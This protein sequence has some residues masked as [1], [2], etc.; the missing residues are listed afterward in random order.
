MDILA[1]RVGAHPG[2]ARPGLATADRRRARCAKILGHYFAIIGYAEGPELVRVLACAM[3]DL[4]LGAAPRAAVVHARNRLDAWLR[5]LTEGPLGLCAVT[6]ETARAALITLTV[7]RDWPTDL[8]AES[9]SADF[10]AA[11][12]DAL[13]L[14]LPPESPLPM[15]EQSLD[16]ARGV[17][18]NP[19]PMPRVPG[20]RTRRA[21]VFGLT[22]V[23]TTAAT[24]QMSRVFQPGGISEI[25]ILLMVL[26]AINFLWIALTFCSGLLGLFTLSRSGLPAGLVAPQVN[27]RAPRTAILI[28]IYNEDPVRIF[29]GVTA[30]YGSLHATGELAAFDFY[31]LS[32]STKPDAW[33]AEEILWDATRRRLGATGRLFYRRRFDNTARKAGNLAEFCQRWGGHYEAMLV[34]DADSLMEGRTIV[35]MARIMAANPSVGLLQTVPLLINRNTL[36][37]RAQQFASRVY[38]PVLATGLAAWHGGDGNYWGH[39]AMLRVRAFAAH[40]GMPALAGRPPFGGHILSHDFVEAA[41]L[42]RAG[43]G[44][45]MLPALGGSFEESPPTLLDHAQRDRRWCQGN[46]QHMA[47]IGAA[48]LH[49]M[50]RFHLLTGIMS[51]LASP[52]WFGFIVTGILAALQTRVELPQYF[53]PNRTPYPVWHVIDP[54]LAV[55]LL[56]TTMAVLL[57]PKVFGWLALAVQPALAASFGGRRRAGLN[58]VFETLVSALTAPVQML[59]QS[60]FVIDV[61]RGRDSGWKTQ[62][63]SERGLSL[64]EAWQ[65]HQHHASA[66][67]LLGIA[68]FAV[69]PLLLGWMA[70]ALAGMLGAAGVSYVG[71]RLHLGLAARR[72][73][74]LLIPEE[75]EVP[76]IAR[77]AN[78]A[79]QTLCAPVLTSGLAAVVTDHR[80]GALHLAL[81]SQYAPSAVNEL[82]ALAHY[83]AHHLRPHAVPPA[84]L[85]PRLHAAALADGPTII[86]LRRLVGRY[87]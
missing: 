45:F 60:R 55:G 85:E 79:S 43:W 9:P 31:V 28:P 35:E 40:A 67:L 53:F 11:F 34:L 63:R 5:Q 10:L 84:I 3:R 48:G 33:V 58:V 21:F 68:A 46:L 73:G 54:A 47:V 81:L 32:D 17:A 14:A 51:Y 41:L 49:P 15:P 42:R 74:L 71:S 19:L 1:A 24:F 12:G 66:G 75:I 22:L 52:L 38:G 30:M 26:F 56:A 8:F 6:P 69:S 59:F 27:A 16:T 23:G 2:C 82:M 77:R 37:A 70:P 64:G 76:E 7:G 57:A 78:A 20:L 62:T 13:P 25:E 61:L 18:L 29:A 44:V 87:S 72:A 86:R 4:P 80:I 39:N 83:R 65:H 50:S 36:F